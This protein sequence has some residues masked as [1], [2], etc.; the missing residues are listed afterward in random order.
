MWE[1]PPR[2]FSERSEP[3][4]TNKEAG[5]P[6]RHDFR[7]VATEAAVSGTLLRN[8]SQRL[9]SGD[10]FRSQTFQFG[11]GALSIF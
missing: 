9:V 7:R 2:L 4:F 8:Q 3:F 6:T 11:D 5:C 1:Q 10:E